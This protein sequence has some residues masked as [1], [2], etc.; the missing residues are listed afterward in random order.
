MKYDYKLVLLLY[1]ILLLIKNKNAT[2]NIE[3]LHVNLLRG[4][5]S[6]RSVG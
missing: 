5:V 2:I 1:R 3:S 6:T 4:I